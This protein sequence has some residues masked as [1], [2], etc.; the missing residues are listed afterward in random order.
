MYRKLNT[1]LIA[2]TSIVLEAGLDMNSAESHCSSYYAATRN[3]PTE[4]S[5]LAGDYQT[6]VCVVGAGFTGIATALTLAER[7]IRPI[8]VPAHYTARL[9]PPSA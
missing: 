5:P 1:H 2:I 3:D 6:D 4:Y 7:G 9:C 8:T